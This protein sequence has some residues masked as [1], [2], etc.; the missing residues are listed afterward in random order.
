MADQKIIDAFLRGVAYHEAITSGNTPA[1]ARAFAE[2]MLFSN[3]DYA[4]THAGFKALEALGYRTAK[5]AIGESSAVARALADKI[6]RALAGPD[7]D[8]VHLDAAA[9][10]AVSLHLRMK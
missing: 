6:D 5:K 3:Q 4:T 8:T 2:G 7:K 9:A 10:S 1:A